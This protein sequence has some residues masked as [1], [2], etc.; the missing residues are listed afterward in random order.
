MLPEKVCYCFVL[1]AE[2]IGENI[3]LRVH[4]NLRL[5]WLNVVCLELEFQ[6]RLIPQAHTL[7]GAQPDFFH[8]PVCL[9]YYK[10]WNNLTYSTILQVHTFVA[11]LAR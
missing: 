3:L 6:S 10:Q 2:K 11:I 9:E 8:L 7:L 4:V 5:S 1:K